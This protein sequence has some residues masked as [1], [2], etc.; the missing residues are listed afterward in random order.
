MRWLEAPRRQSCLLALVVMCAG[1][2]GGAPPRAA[3]TPADSHAAPQTHAP[4]PEAVRVTRGACNLE[5]IPTELLL[6][7]SDAEARALTAFVG[8]WL[9]GASAPQIAWRKGIAFAKSED[10]TGADPPYPTAVNAQSL[11][12][13]GLAQRWLRSHLELE[14]AERGRGDGGIACQQNVCCWLPRM[15]FDSGGAVVFGRPAEPTGAWVVRA[16]V[17]VADNGALMRETVAANRAKV[18]RGLAGLLRQTC[19]D[20]PKNPYGQPDP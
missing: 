11:L 7:L 10:D 2:C 4:A 1:G 17:E 20:E 3:L 18:R 9:A 12:A 13:C 5:A 8:Q 19:D 6:D 16:A 14:L 15:E